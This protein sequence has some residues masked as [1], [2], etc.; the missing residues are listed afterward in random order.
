MADSAKTGENARCVT[1][2]E[3]FWIEWNKKKNKKMMKSCSPALDPA[4][5]S[6]P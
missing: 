1:C 3:D 6:T 4:S 2:F 5:Q